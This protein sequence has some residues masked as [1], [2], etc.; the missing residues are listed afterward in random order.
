MS[1][2]PVRMARVNVASRQ[3][4]SDVYSLRLELCKV[5][6]KQLGKKIDVVTKD[7]SFSSQDLA[8]EL[9]RLAGKESE[10]KRQLREVGARFRELKTEQRSAQTATG[11]A[12]HEAAVPETDAWRVAVESYQSEVLI[13]DQRLETLTA[14]QQLWKRRYQLANK[15]LDRAEMSSWQDESIEFLQRLKDESHALD[16]RRDS[17]RQAM[18]TVAHL[19]DEAAKR[20]QSEFDRHREL[21]DVIGAS[22]LEIKS[23]ERTIE[24]FRQELSSRLEQSGSTF[25]NLSR[26][27]LSLVGWKVAETDGHPVTVGKLVLL[28][29]TVAAGIVGAYYVS[30]WIGRRVLRRLGVSRGKRVAIRSIVFYVLCLVSGII[31]FRLLNIPLAAFAFVGGAAAIAIGFG[32]QDIMNNFMSGLIL[33]AEQPIRV[34]D[35]IELGAVE[36]S[37]VHIGMRSTRLRTQLNHE[38]IVPNKS[39]LDEQVTNYTLSDNVVRRSVKMTVERSVPILEAKKKMLRVVKS[40]PLVLDVPRPVVVVKEIDNY[41]GTTTFEVFF[42]MHLNSFMECAVVQGKI[43][44]K[45]GDLFPPARTTGNSNEAQ[46]SS[47]GDD[48]APLNGLIRGNDAALIKELRK[49]QARMRAK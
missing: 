10:I 36:G 18:N 48:Q 30:R 25:D 22:L 47:A 46:N 23:A 20:V 49:V 19:R 43:L 6:Q 11:Q 14:L 27:L 33:L 15:P 21:L 12:S 37:V 16:Q 8:Q 45:I 26:S 3:I 17:I 44:Q 38:L 2:L 39:L 42:A 24:R 35:V 13:L 32:S 29:V 1:R 41:Y 40:Q 4:E 34:G 7:V 28:L 31:A 5:R 9:A